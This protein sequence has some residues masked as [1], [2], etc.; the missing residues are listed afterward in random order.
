MI[1][2]NSVRDDL[3]PLVLLPLPSTGITPGATILGLCNA[4]VE[5]RAS[6]M[7]GTELPTEPHPSP[8]VPPSSAAP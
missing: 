8:A 2:S 4:G 6:G 5:P 1:G 7:L 3:E